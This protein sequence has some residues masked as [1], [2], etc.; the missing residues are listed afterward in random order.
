M[1]SH[2][3][4]YVLNIKISTGDHCTPMEWRVISRNQIPSC[5]HPNHANITKWVDA[6]EASLLTHNAHLGVHTVVSAT[7]YDQVDKKMVCE[8][9][10]SGI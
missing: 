10:R 6:Y 3:I 5:G 1:G 9:D 7:I 4:R 8:W 2:V